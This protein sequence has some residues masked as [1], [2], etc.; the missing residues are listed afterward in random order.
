MEELSDQGVP[1]RFLMELSVT[2]VD[3]TA[4]VKQ[5]QICASVVCE[6]GNMMWLQAVVWPWVKDASF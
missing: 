4:L 2:A 3:N 6:Q 5:Q 1:T